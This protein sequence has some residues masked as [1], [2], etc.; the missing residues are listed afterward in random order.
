MRESLNNQ[1]LGL[2]LMVSVILYSILGLAT[3]DG[4]DPGVLSI[5]HRVVFYST[6]AIS[7]VSIHQI[8]DLHPIIKIFF[9]LSLIPIFNVDTGAPDLLLRERYRWLFYTSAIVLADIRN[10]RI[11]IQLLLYMMVINIFAPLLFTDSY[12][13]ANDWDYEVEKFPSVLIMGGVFIF[14]IQ[15]KLSSLGKTILYVSFIV[16]LLVYVYYA[17]RTASVYIL[18]FMLSPFLTTVGGLGKKLKVGIITLL[19]SAFL[20]FV[21]MESVSFNLFDYFIERLD[22]D[23]RAE[24]DFLTLAAI[25]MGDGWLFGL[26]VQGGYPNPIIHETAAIRVYVETGVLDVIMDGGIF[27]WIS[28]MAMSIYGCYLGYFKSNNDIIKNMSFVLLVFILMQYP[29]PQAGISMN[30]LMIFMSVGLCYNKKYREYTNEQIY[31]IIKI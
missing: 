1:K 8:K 25:Q 3:D 12:F 24:V 17:R 27:L 31:E 19:V 18:L 2:S 29:I 23:S 15:K 26:G 28:M 14:G 20:I 6:V 22:A 30:G 21:V 16:T 11:W 4:S 10:M 7:L 13:P 9:L 5:I